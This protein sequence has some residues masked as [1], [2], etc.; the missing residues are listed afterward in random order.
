MKIEKAVKIL[1]IM[2]VEPHPQ[3]HPDNFDAIKLSIEALK[4]LSIVREGS[5]GKFPP[6]LPDET[7]E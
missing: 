3:W 1:G 5:I 4:F 6:Q 2:L 7:E